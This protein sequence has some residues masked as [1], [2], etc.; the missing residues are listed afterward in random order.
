MMMFSLFACQSAEEKARIEEIA[1]RVAMTDEELDRIETELTKY[2]ET[3]V[4]VED[5]ELLMTLKSELDAINLEFKCESVDCKDKHS[6][7]CP[8]IKMVNLYATLGTVIA[9]VDKLQA[10]AYVK[11]EA[12]AKAKAEAEAKKID[13]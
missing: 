11:A 3:T 13:M 5:S 9:K 8:E 6:E 10:E 4:T 7:D 2:N 12:E 1:K